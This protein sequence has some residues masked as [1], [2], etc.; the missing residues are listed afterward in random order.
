MTISSLGRSINLSSPTGIRSNTTS[1][2]STLIPFQLNSPTGCEM[3][4]HERDVFTPEP[5]IL[6]VLFFSSLI[7]SSLPLL[8]LR[9]QWTTSPIS[10]SKTSSTWER[11]VPTKKASTDPLPCPPMLVST[12]HTCISTEVKCT[13]G[14]DV[15][16][17]NSLLSAMA[18]AS[19]SSPVADLSHSMFMSQ[20]TTSSAT[21]KCQPMLHSAMELTNRCWD[22]PTDTT[23]AS[24]A[25]GE[26]P[27]S[28]AA[29][30]TGCSPS[31]NERENPSGSTS[32]DRRLRRVLIRLFKL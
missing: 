10:L 22:G 28:G 4:A 26:W 29:S 25:C 20:D 1:M 31:T 7:A 19:G 18:N 21:A 3:K 6:K 13:T 23:E 27:P 11:A 32:I 5:K 24:G 12:P 30:C 14:V 8:G 16:T 17:P 9:S 15:V 2:L